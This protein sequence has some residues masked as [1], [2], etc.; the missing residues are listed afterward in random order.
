MDHQGER[1]AYR[2]TEDF[3]EM[4]R[5]SKGLTRESSEARLRCWKAAEVVQPHFGSHPGTVLKVRPVLPL[6]SRNLVT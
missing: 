6:L 4:R 5:R 3:L 2:K 1:R